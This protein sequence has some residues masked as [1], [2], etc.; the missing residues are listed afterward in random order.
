MKFID[1]PV[2][3]VEETGVSGDNH[4]PVANHWQTLSHNVD[5]VHLAMNGIGTDCTGSCTSNGV[6]HHNLLKPY[7]CCYKG[8]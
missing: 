8:R 1:F 6:K 7:N 2:L 3:L 5:G 4:R